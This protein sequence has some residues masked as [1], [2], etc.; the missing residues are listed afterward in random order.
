MHVLA[1]QR[2]C[3][4]GEHGPSAINSS[5]GDGPDR[6]PLPQRRR[7]KER[8]VL[9]PAQPQLPGRALCR[10]LA[11]AVRRKEAA[12]RSFPGCPERELRMCRLNASDHELLTDVEVADAAGDQLP[13][14]HHEAPA[15][16]A[17]PPH[18]GPTPCST[19]PEGCVGGRTGSGTR[20]PPGM[21]GGLLRKPSSHERHAAGVG[22]SAPTAALS[23]M[24]SRGEREPIVRGR[25]SAHLDERWANGRSRPGHY[26]QAVSH[27]VKLPL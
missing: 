10:L 9:H 15:V 21:R 12:L 11:G 14:D 16:P 8:A 18:P 5:A 25:D 22:D 20:R 24:A 17:R 4:T 19:R 27:T 23:T 26:G 2:V 3:H 1:Q 7:F 6:P 13:S